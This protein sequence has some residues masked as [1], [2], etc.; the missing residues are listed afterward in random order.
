MATS[1]FIYLPSAQNTFVWDAQVFIAD[2]PSIRGLDKLSSIFTEPSSLPNEYQGE[3]I[4]FLPYYRPFN[5]A[6]Q[7]LTFSAF[8]DQ[9]LGYKVV[10]ML[11]HGGVCLLVWLLFVSVTKNR[12]LST[13]AALLYAVKPVHVEAVAWS[14]S[15][16]YLLT[17]FFALLALLLYRHGPRWLALIGFASALMFN[18]LGVLLLPVLFLHRWLL[19]GKYRP[20][21][22]IALLPY[23]AITLGFITLR[24]AVVGA[25]PLT[26]VDP[27][28]FMHTS[29]VVLQKY[30]KIFFWP[31]APVTIYLA[32][33]YS[34]LSAEVVLSYFVLLGVAS[35]S[36]V[37]W[38]RDRIGLFWLLW[39][40]VW[41]AV[42][43]NIGRFND[44]LMAEKLAYIAA[45]GPSMLLVH[46]LNRA[47]KGKLPLTAV[48]VISLVILQGFNTWTRLPHWQN[49][50]TYLTEGLNF[51]PDF[52]NGHYSLAQTY[53][54]SGNYDQAQQHLEKS[55]ELKPGFSLALNNL[56]NIH[57]LKRN[58]G[59]AIDYW[60]QALRND[61]SNPQPYF[62]IGMTLQQQG[63]ISEARAYYQ[64]Y[65]TLEPNPQPAVIAV[66]APLMRQR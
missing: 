3:A 43:F 33:T 42:S 10:N 17:A 19:E 60:Q 63:R 23:V 20:A 52:Y 35:L 16:S 64:R 41:I 65:L 26:E 1:I 61:P 36:I 18:E 48:I 6:F 24:S 9:P 45:I 66:I 30:L 51:A 44:Y 50:Q 62:N 14:Y 4:S 53:I 5:K 55:I 40:L 34:Q 8:G 56:A 39:F 25:V 49:T 32:K 28:T 11:L 12:S 47:L 38:F 37:L 46:W 57:F 15:A 13:L 2:N 58:H 29:A 54:N 31:D 22:F 7:I 59:R 21:E 27:I